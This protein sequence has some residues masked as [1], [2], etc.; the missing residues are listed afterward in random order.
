[1]PEV[2]VPWGQEELTLVLP[3]HWKVQQTAAASLPA[4]RKDWPELLAR[5][6]NQPDAGSPLSRLLAE[7]RRGQIVLIVEDITRHSRLP[8]ILPILM[9]EIDHAGISREQ[10]EIVFATG[11]HP[12][13][14][15]EQATAKLGGGMGDIRRRCN[16]WHDKSEYTCIGRAGKI[17]LYI[18]RGVVAADLRIIVSSVSAHLQAG[19]GGGY[20]MILP[21]CAHLETV[22]SLHRLGLGR[23]ARQLVGTDAADNAMRAAIDAG[24]RRI[25]AV[26][27]KTFAVQYLLDEANL[28][29]LIAT[30]EAIPA[31]RMLAKQCSVACGVVTPSPADVLITNAHP[32][33]L[34]LWQSFKCIANTCWAV[35]PNGIIICLARCPEGMQGMNVPRWPLRAS[36]TRRILRMLG[37]DALYSMVTRLLPHLAGDAGFFIRQATRM[38][39]RNPILMVSAALCET[40]RRFPGLELFATPEDAF[41]AAG[42]FLEAGTQRVTVFP[43][44]GI[45]FPIPPA[46]ARGAAGKAAGTT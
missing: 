18:D 6:L 41:A 13:M 37:P 7:C 24:G 46:A 17:P 16:P 15:P 20:K 39:H 31:Q 38:L 8:D 21:G 28:P 35:R 45:T 29:A 30:G 22:R 40:G 42:R 34:D 33:D 14:T 32:R 26:A 36:W 1:M 10:I 27:G 2:A 9:R 43:N 5:S 3:D 23:R 25:E 4:A 11:M 12:P 44:G 19:F